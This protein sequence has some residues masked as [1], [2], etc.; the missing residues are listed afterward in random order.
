MK[1]FLSIA[2]ILLLPS[3]IFAES[4]YIDSFTSDITV[5]EN[6]VYT[7]HETIDVY[8]TSPSHGIYRVIP[9]RDE[10]IRAEIGIEAVN[11]D[12]STEENS[13]YLVLRMGSADEYVTGPV[14]YE[15]VYTYDPGADPYTDY[16]EFY[17]NIIGF[18]QV[19]IREAS[20]S[21]HFPTAIDSSRIWVTYGDYG[22]DARVPFDLSSDGRTLSIAPVSLSPE[23][24]ITVRTEMDEGYFIGARVP[25]DYSALVLVLMP[26]LTAV[27]AVVII[28]IYRKYGVDR[29]LVIAAR[30]EP[31]RGLSPLDIGY[32]YDN[33]TD[34]RDYTAMLFYWADKGY[35]RIHEP[36]K[37]V[38]L[39]EKL[40]EA[41]FERSY[42]CELFNA[43]FS[44]GDK[45]TASDVSS[46]K[47]LEILS[48]T[49]KPSVSRRFSSG[50]EAVQNSKSQQMASVSAGIT[51]VFAIIGALLASLDDFSMAFFMVLITA[52]SAVIQLLVLFRYQNRK[53]SKGRGYTVFISIISIFLVLFATFF[54]A[55]IMMDTMFSGAAQAVIVA[56]TAPGI[57]IFSALAAATGKRSDYGQEI[58]EEILGYREF[59]QRAELPELERMI[60]SDPQFYYHTLSYAIV[61]SLEEKWSRKF[62]NIYME[63]A[64]WYYGPD[65]VVDYIFYST[66]FR[67]FNNNYTAR[68]VVPPV[69]TSSLHRGGSSSFSGFS[70][71]SGGGHGGGGGGSW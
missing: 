68:A 26:L 32:L 62:Q 65:P 27:C 50:S 19:P 2:I 24:D 52:Q 36:K 41:D 54:I 56:C 18:W 30:F 53:Q 40:K 3:L 38:F 67:R 48:G 6:S 59:I 66:L 16:D 60:A 11:T 10:T 61:F 20:F 57:A 71:F 1:R 55:I 46:T 49:V 42:E 47:F 7:I 35:L 22:S 13:E 5:A 70:G 12:F 51:V 28:L 8:F 44:K 33:A 34:S 31:P 29:P 4:F 63:P 43:F 37:G 23:Q 25:A 64:R 21:I 9:V 15:L 58:L 69:N 39:L 17:M 14:R 45:V